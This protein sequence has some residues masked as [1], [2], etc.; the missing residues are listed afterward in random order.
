MTVYFKAKLN[1]ICQI[2]VLTGVNLVNA[3]VKKKKA[4]L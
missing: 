2:E 3:C 4:G 1:I